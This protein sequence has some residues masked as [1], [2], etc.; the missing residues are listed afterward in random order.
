LP[1][2]RL[3]CGVRAIRILTSGVSHEKKHVV[4]LRAKEREYLTRLVSSSK[5]SAFTQTRAHVLL[6]ADAPP[7]GPGWDDVRIAL[8]VRALTPTLD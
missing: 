6:K 4:S 7:A 8:P 2:A 3:Q 1:S 5:T